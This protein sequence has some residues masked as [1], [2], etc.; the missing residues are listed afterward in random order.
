MC[1]SGLT[2]ALMAY[3]LA[4]GFPAIQLSLRLVLQALVT[5]DTDRVLCLSY[6]PVLSYVCF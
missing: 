3:I 5:D 2:A 1:G 4:A 6:V